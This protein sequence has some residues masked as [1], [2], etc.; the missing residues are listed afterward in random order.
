MSAWQRS[1]ARPVLRRPTEPPD[2]TDT[3]AYEDRARTLEHAR[4]AT[5]ARST[6]FFFVWA[7]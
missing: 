3:V 7:T 5:M 6:F 1:Q 2:L 4:Q